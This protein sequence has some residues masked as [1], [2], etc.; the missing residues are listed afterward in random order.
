METQIFCFSLN[1]KRCWHWF[2]FWKQRWLTFQRES[3]FQE[4]QRCSL[5]YFLKGGSSSI[6][7]PIRPT[8]MVMEKNWIYIPHCW[9]IERFDS[10][11]WLRTTEWFRKGTGSAYSVY[12]IR[13][14]R[15]VAELG[16]QDPQVFLV[17]P[18]PIYIP[19]NPILQWP[20]WLL[21]ASGY[22]SSAW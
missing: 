16:C 22:W 11:H 15:W 19:S 17:L 9:N 5:C 7:L 13:L 10:H 1:N 12:T 21:R 3:C 6:A 4:E 2:A 20:S 14:L 18:D 8:H